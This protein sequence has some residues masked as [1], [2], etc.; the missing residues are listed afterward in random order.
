MRYAHVNKMPGGKTEKHVKDYVK[1]VLNAYDIFWW[2]SPANGYGVSGIS[3]FGALAAG[4]FF[5]IET[6]ANKNKPTA[7]Q[8][9]YLRS[10][11]REGGIALV[12]YDTTQDV[13]ARFMACFAQSVKLTAEGKDPTIEVGG[14]MLDAL[15]ILTEPW[16]T[17]DV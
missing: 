13:F 1:H 12:V 9:A 11:D 8:K 7:M 4:T 3:D 15:K 2:M 10:I 16:M 5:A 17:T 6:K 14:P